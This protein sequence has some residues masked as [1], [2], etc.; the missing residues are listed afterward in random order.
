M[1]FSRY[2]NIFEYILI[3]RA[4]VAGDVLQATALLIKLLIGSSHM[5]HVMRHMSC[6]LCFIC[7]VSG[8]TCILFY[9]FSGIYIY[10]WSGSIPIF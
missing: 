7:H 8:V 4:S 2:L 10:I 3:K 6:V 9:K 1:A 5:S